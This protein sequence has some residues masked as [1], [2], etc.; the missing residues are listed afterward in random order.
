[1]APA[2]AAA[3]SLTASDFVVLAIVFGACA[4]GLAGGLLGLSEYLTAKRLRVSLRATK[5]KARAMLSARD[6]WLAGAR[7]SLIV[8]GADM[9]API[10]FGDSPALIEACLAGP[11]ATDLSTA[12]D[13]LAANGAAFALAART[14]DGRLVHVRGR[15]AGGYAAVYLDVETRKDGEL[16]DYRPILDA[17]PVPVWLRRAPDLA[18]T[19][20]NRA[21]LAVSGAPAAE[22]ALSGN[23]AI[24]RSERD[25][26]TTARSNGEVVEAKRFA[27]LGGHRR[28]LHFTLSPLPDGAVL[29]SASDIT[30][31]AEAESR[32]Q[33]HMDAHSDTLD[34]L[35]TAVAIFG[36]DRR[37]SFYNQAYVRLWGL[38]ET[39]LDAHPSKGEILDRLRE[40]RRLPEQ[41]DFRAW[42]QERLKQFENL[43]QHPEELWHL[44]GGKT[45]RVVMQPH[46]FGGM[47]FLYEDV[48]DQLRLESSYNTL[49]K[50]QKATLDTLQE[51]VAVFGPDGRLKLYN[52]AFAR[53][54]LLEPSE[55]SE[56]PHLNR[57]AGLCAMRFGRD[58]A[59][60]IVTSTVTAASPERQREW[61]EV[62]RSDGKII[63]LT[64]APLLS[65]GSPNRPTRGPLS[66][67]R[68][69]STRPT[70][71]VSRPRYANA[72]R[73][74]KRR[75]N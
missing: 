47:T 28:A 64:I 62:E 52:A 7:E 9:N 39:W 53:I 60:E 56:E 61:G 23:I 41:P 22:S 3:L 46:P 50:V 26:A 66:R 1:M 37:L 68:A 69:S 49:I 32:L 12:L 36:P 59:W 24:D 71:S 31:Q 35:A 33:Q 54:W 72:T 2:A 34:K 13:A 38:S 4:L 18:L 8:W 70:D 74:W 55:L 73:R 17:L 19:F 40:L 42:R 67:L 58:R 29:G 15:P 51:G 65:T 11:D 45:L 43:D 14:S 57:I 16:P 6:V 48:S 63:S 25:L 44:P 5:A 21:F 75:T 30:A 10:S 27:V 20:V